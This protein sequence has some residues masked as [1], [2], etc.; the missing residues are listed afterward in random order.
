MNRKLRRERTLL[1]HKVAEEASGEGR[2]QLG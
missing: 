2:E 1:V